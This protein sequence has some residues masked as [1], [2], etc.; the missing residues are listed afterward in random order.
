MKK[1]FLIL[2]MV[3]WVF[4]EYYK[5]ESY[6][7]DVGSALIWQDQEYTQEEIDAYSAGS[8]VGKVQNFASAISYCENLELDGYNDWR[9]PN[10]TELYLLVDRNQTTPAVDS[11]FEHIANGKYWSST[12]VD[13][14]NSMGWIVDFEHGNSEWLAKDTKAYVRCIRN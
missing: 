8:A 12:T 6:V 10:F 11:T 7:V 4:G 2:L 13:I 9:L 3:T 1:V 5:E 14:D